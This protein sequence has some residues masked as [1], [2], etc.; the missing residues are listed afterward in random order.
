MREPTSERIEL[1]RGLWPGSAKGKPGEA[2]FQRAAAGARTRIVR[3]RHVRQTTTGGSMLLLA[4]G[5][6][7]G[8]LHVTGSEESVATDTQPVHKE[9]IATQF[10]NARFTIQRATGAEL[11]G[12][13]IVG[14]TIEGTRLALTVDRGGEL[15]FE[16]V[17]G[18]RLQLSSETELTLEVGEPLRVDLQNGAVLLEGHFAVAG[19][20]C[21][22]EL[23]G[24]ARVEVEQAPGGFVRTH[25]SVIAGD[26]TVSPDSSCIT[27]LT[28]IELPDPNAASHAVR[29]EPTPSPEEEVL[30]VA[31]AAD[32]GAIIAERVDRLAEAQMLMRRDPVAALEALERLS[33][34][35]PDA[36]V[37]EELDASIV[38]ALV[39]GGR[40]EQARR[41]AERLVSRYGASR[42]GDLLEQVRTL[43]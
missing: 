15:A 4:V 24:R 34:E 35:W 18:D 42:Y 3:R 19:P 40:A 30:D 39:R 31:A 36:P 21:A 28:V 16:S 37:R 27:P 2:L 22:C 33:A 29:R 17:R 9:P 1:L 26:M 25:V 38:E 7:Y 11:A 23:D 32:P 14:E 5:V 20:S 13:T 10:P 8:G 12:Q 43:P 6:V 41:A